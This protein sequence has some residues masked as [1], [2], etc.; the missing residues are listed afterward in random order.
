MITGISKYILHNYSNFRAQSLLELFCTLKRISIF[1][2]SNFFHKNIPS[3]AGTV[4]KK[5]KRV[6]LYNELFKRFFN[7]NCK[8]TNITFKPRISI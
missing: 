4:K 2:L 5:E 8:T 7:L 6:R 1:F 3:K